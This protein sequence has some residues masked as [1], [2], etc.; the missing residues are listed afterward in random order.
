MEG[1]G[2]DFGDHISSQKVVYSQVCRRS[3]QMLKNYLKSV[4]PRRTILR[5]AQDGRAEKASSVR[6]ELVEPFFEMVT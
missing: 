5:Q 6:G 4:N 3:V 2:S 1:Y